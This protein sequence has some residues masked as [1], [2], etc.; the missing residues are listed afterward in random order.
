MDD[1]LVWNGHIDDP[2][3]V[4]DDPAHMKL[5]EATHRFDVPVEWL[6]PHY[7]DHEM[8]ERLARVSAP[9]G[10]LELGGSG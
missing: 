8:V 7:R 3:P 9:R 4:R 1:L 6:R 2:A 5:V 10:G